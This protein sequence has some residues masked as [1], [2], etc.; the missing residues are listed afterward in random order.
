M[1]KVALVTG[2]TRGIGEAISRKLKDDG[3]TVIA[4]YTSNDEKAKAFKEETEQRKRKLEGK[5]ERTHSCSSYYSPIRVSDVIRD[6][7]GCFFTFLTSS[8]VYFNVS[9]N[10]NYK[11]TIE[12]E[13]H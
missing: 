13:R 2:G 9:T 12:D 3:L 8:L 11:Y 5:K 10:T 4:N 1:S 6:L 7:H